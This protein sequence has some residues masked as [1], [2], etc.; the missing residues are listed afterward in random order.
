M[1]AE[2]TTIATAG[3]LYIG[4]APASRAK[5][6]KAFPQAPRPLP[7]L[8]TQPNA[9][10]PC[11]HHTER[12]LPWWVSAFPLTGHLNTQDLMQMQPSLP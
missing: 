11:C 6:N 5:L 12:L 8:V 1:V 7:S 10:T 3:C 4:G 2:L 9:Q